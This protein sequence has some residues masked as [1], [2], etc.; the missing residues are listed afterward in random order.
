M[1]EALIRDESCSL[2]DAL[3]ARLRDAIFTCSIPVNLMLNEQHVA[4]EYGVSKLTARETLKRLCA[5]KLLVSYPRK[6]YLVNQI[7]AAQCTQMQQ[8]RYQVEGFAIR[9]IIRRRSDEEIRSLLPILDMEG[10]GSDPYGTINYQFHTALAR[11]SGSP[12]IEDTLSSYIGQICRYAISMA[13]KG[14]YTKETSHH[15]QMV[16]AMLAR[17]AQA[18]LEEL[19]LDLCLDKEEI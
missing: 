11:L 19:R 17:D 7:S 8:V 5:E 2:A 14:M 10:D 6:G 12:Y 1:S 3:Y 4:A 9:E 16:E 13:P 15:R 18:A